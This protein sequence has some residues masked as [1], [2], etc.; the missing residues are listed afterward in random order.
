MDQS[1]LPTA[2]RKNTA[3]KHAIIQLVIVKISSKYA[4]PARK[5]LQFRHIRLNVNTARPNVTGLRQDKCI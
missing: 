1:F 5:Y 2:L 3:Q 4:Q